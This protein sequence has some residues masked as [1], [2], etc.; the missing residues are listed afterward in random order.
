MYK[1]KCDGCGLESS[2]RRES[3]DHWAPDERRATLRQCSGTWRLVDEQPAKVK[4][5]GCGR[6]TEYRG[7]A[8]GIQPDTAADHGRLGAPTVQCTGTWRL[9]DEQPA[10]PPLTVQEAEKLVVCQKEGHRRDGSA[11]ARIDPANI[12]CSVHSW[13]FHAEDG[14]GH[15]HLE[16]AAVK[17]GAAIDAIALGQ[18]KPAL[19]GDSNRPQQACDVCGD[20]VRRLGTWKWHC[21]AHRVALA[22]QLPP[23]PAEPRWPVEALARA[24]F[25]HRMLEEAMERSEYDEDTGIVEQV[26]IHDPR[27]EHVLDVMWA[28]TKPVERRAAETMATRLVARMKNK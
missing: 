13:D 7:T 2:S 24:L 18:K 26:E 9:V 14:C 11:W 12:W 28:K 17:A 27:R 8:G 22:K 15:C 23:H 21:D 25:D 20:G 1:V 3:G 4:C 19:S 5:D 6:V 16:A 10:K